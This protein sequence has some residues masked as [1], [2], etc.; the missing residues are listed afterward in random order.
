MKY[1]KT[2]EGVRDKMLPK[3]TE[4]IKKS[5]VGLSDNDIK[6]KFFDSMWKQIKIEISEE[7]EDAI[8]QREERTVYSST[9]YITDRYDD[10]DNLNKIYNKINQYSDICVKSTYNG[11]SALKIRYEEHKQFNEGVNNNLI[12]R[13]GTED[14]LVSIKRLTN[15]LRNDLPFVMNVVLKD[16]I[17]RDELYV[18]ESMGD[19]VGFVHF[20]KRNDGWT[21][22]HEIGVS[23]DFQRMSIGEKL[24]QF[25]PKPI[26]LKTTTDNEKSNNF[27]KKLGLKLIKKEKGK[28]RELNVWVDDESTNESIRDKMTPKSKEEVLKSLINLT[29]MEKLIKGIDNNIF[30]LVKQNFE[31][32]NEK[33]IASDIL[34]FIGWYHMNHL[35]DH[36]SVEIMSYLLEKGYKPSKDIFE[37]AV[38]ECSVE[39]IKLFIDNGV[40]VND[41]IVEYATYWRNRNYSSDIP[42]EKE[43][44]EVIKLLQKHNMDNKTNKLKK[45]MHFESIRDKMIPKSEEEI[46]KSIDKLSPIDKIFRGIDQEL[47]WLVQEG[48]D[49]GADVCGSKKGNDGNMYTCLEFA[50]IKANIKIMKLLLKNGASKR[51]YNRDA[52]I[53]FLNNYNN[54]KYIQT[55]IL[56]D[57]Y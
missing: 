38:I 56:L 55:R 13:K 1:L 17:K 44:E 46:R 20:Y 19:I 43:K 23:P 29:T 10:E 30:W 16:A 48:I 39:F 11:H 37:R 35:V 12:F 32:L 49:D 9:Y 4:D 27:Y 2:Y 36:N 14:D 31:E 45:F 6:K 25:V 54:K 21:T 8:F 18:C 53:H 26:K 41:E 50:C 40:V 52:C 47:I 33:M 5:L 57:N 34:R 22:L 7:F 15:K 42:A 28:T 24:Y 3:S 51:N